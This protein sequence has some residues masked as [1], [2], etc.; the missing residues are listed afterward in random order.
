MAS[1][2]TALA[3]LVAV[4]NV[5][6]GT[7]LAWGV[8]GGDD[9]TS[10]VRALLGIALFGSLV[11][12][13][14]TVLSVLEPLPRWIVAG[15][16]VVAAAAGML[17]VASDDSSRRRSLA[18]IMGA[19]AVLAALAAAW[20]GGLVTPGWRPVLIGLIPPVVFAS[21]GAIAREEWVEGDAVALV[22][23]LGVLLVPSALLTVVALIG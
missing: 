12:M 16:L 22:L 7:V 3:A 18:M 6:Y 15:G 14:V 23:V 13:A 19:V 5:F 10:A 8:S 11:W 1:F 2:L 4:A 21:A 20:L 17:A 9:Q